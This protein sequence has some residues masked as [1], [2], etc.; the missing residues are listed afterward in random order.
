MPILYFKSSICYIRLLRVGFPEKDKE[1]PS[2]SV[3]NSDTDRAE[4]GVKL[5]HRHDRMIFHEENKQN[6]AT[7][8]YNNLTFESW[9]DLRKINAIFQNLRKKKSL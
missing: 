9:S 6:S 8:R 5:E 2:K 1:T 7:A 4:S 3:T